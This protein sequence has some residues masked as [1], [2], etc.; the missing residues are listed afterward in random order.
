MRDGTKY[1]VEPFAMERLAHEDG[2]PG[3]EGLPHG[4]SVVIACKPNDGYPAVH[5]GSPDPPDEGKPLHS[6]HGSVNHGAVKPLFVR[7][8]R[9]FV[10][11]RA[12]AGCVLNLFDRPSL[13]N[14][15]SLL[16]NTRWLSF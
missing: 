4:G 5:G 6:R 14:R 12:L 13:P 8:A 7:K 10:G 16:E 1:A 11:E 3:L 2:R 9:R 15:K